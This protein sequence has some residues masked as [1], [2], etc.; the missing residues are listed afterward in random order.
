[1]AEE[2]IWHLDYVV[3]PAAFPALTVNLTF[4]SKSIKVHITKNS[5]M[6][7]VLFSA[8]KAAKKFDACDSNWALHVP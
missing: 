6:L 8:Y 4:P 5:D 7:T 3:S 1:M 2:L